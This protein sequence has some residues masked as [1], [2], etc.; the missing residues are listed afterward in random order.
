[1]LAVRD[2]R[3]ARG[4]FTLSVDALELHAGEVLAVLGPNGAGKSTLLRSLAGLQSPSGGRLESRADGP[5]TLVFQRPAALAGSVTHNV[6]VALLGRSLSR[7]EMSARVGEAL[8][9]FEIG[10]LAE[11]RAATLSGGELRRLALA[12][13]FVLRPAVLL[14]DEPFDDLDA[15]GQAKLSLDLRRAIEDTRVAVAMVTHDLRRALLLAD[16]VA[17]LLDGRLAQVGAR[18]D[19]LTRPRDRAIAEVVGMTNLVRGVVTDQRRGEHPLVEVDAQHR[20]AVA[21]SLSPGTRVWLGI[22]PEHLKLDVGRGEVDPIGKATVESVVSD[23]VASTVV[24]TW[25]GSALSTHLLAGRVLA[26]SL[27]PG[28]PVS[29]SV[30][31]DQ[32]HVMPADAPAG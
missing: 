5:V 14:L 3:V 29:L 8:A 7:D 11:R 30:R 2:L 6:R 19:V 26:R 31:P 13:A 9:R 24:L 1:V 23:G 28:A 4:A 17:V 32:V 22:R 16:R 21:T 18:D 15:G 12:R 20:L 10:R 27:R 25:A